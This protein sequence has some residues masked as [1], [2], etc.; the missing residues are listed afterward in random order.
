MADY[1]S[2]TFKSVGAQYQLQIKW[3]IIRTN[4][5]TLNQYVCLQRLE[6][7]LA[8]FKDELDA[9]F[10]NRLSDSQHPLTEFMRVHEIDQCTSTASL[11]AALA[12]INRDKQMSPEEMA[13]KLMAGY[14]GG[15][16]GLVHPNYYYEFGYKQVEGHNE[17]A[18][19]AHKA[20]LELQ[21]S[22]NDVE[23]ETAGRRSSLNQ[24]SH[25]CQDAFRSSSTT[26]LARASGMAKVEHYLTSG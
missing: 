1:M 13:K 23:S 11:S 15:G 4:W 9:E 21:R 6:R 12:V 19:A 14:T 22:V 24:S 16:S 20:L 17:A 5:N 2:R 18:D 25:A 26:L 3:S 10:M 7:N 8:W